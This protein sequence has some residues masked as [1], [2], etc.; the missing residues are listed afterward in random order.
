MPLHIAHRHTHTD[1]IAA[2]PTHTPHLPIANTDDE[3]FGKEHQNN[4][5]RFVFGTK[6]CV[7][8]YA[9]DMSSHNYASHSHI[10]IVIKVTVFVA[11]ALPPGCQRNSNWMRFIWPVVNNRHGEARTERDKVCVV[12]VSD[13]K[14]WT[15]FTGS[16]WFSLFPISSTIQKIDRCA[17]DHFP[18]WMPRPTYTTI[19]RHI[20]TTTK[21]RGKEASGRSSQR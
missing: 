20:L 15:P 13:D 3:L 2:A 11:S 8:V 21:C 19:C 1:S 6:M 7:C 12:L 10:C 16:V 18:L 17:F 14:T 5:D 4:K 9:I